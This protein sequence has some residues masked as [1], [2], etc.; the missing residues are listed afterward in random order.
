MS[1]IRNALRDVAHPRWGVAYWRARRAR[2]PTERRARY[3]L[4]EHPDS[5]HDSA[6]ALAAVTGAERESCERALEDA[7]LPEPVPGDAAVWWPRDPL[8]R[9]VSAA[10]TL[11]RP[12]TAVEVGVARGYTS[13]AIL[14]AL[15]AA[16]GGRLHSIDLPPRDVD[17][18]EFVGAVVPDRLR[19]NWELILGPSARELPPLAERLGMID[20]FF[21]DGDHSYRSQHEDLETIWPC[22]SPG[23][24]VVMDD[25]WTPAIFDFAAEHGERVAIASWDEHSD[26]VGMLRKG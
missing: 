11:T 16:A 25:I 17:A 18:R 9:A 6:G 7:W 15:D 21:H 2:I 10:T 8:S 3:W 14:G 22:L 5:L 12:A 1:R 13:A 24:V 26:G 20:F 19:R 4:E 23:A